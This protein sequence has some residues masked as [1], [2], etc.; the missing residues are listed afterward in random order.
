MSASSTF[1]PRITRRNAPNFF[2]EPFA[3]RSTALARSLR[4]SSVNAPGIKLD[5]IDAVG[6]GARCSGDTLGPAVDDAVVDRASAASS[7]P[8]DAD[9]AAVDDDDVADTYDRA[10]AL[11]LIAAI[12]RTCSYTRDDALAHSLANEDKP[13]GAVTRANASDVRCNMLGGLRHSRVSPVSSMESTRS[14]RAMLGIT[15][16]TRAR[17]CVA[18]A[19]PRRARA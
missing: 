8:D 15:R 11:V 4:P 2:G 13:C 7:L 5:R 19:A 9:A 16:I 3:P 10:R 6:A 1:K 14:S 17:E 18:S 12:H